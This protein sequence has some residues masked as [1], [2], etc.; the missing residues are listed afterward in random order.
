MPN[1]YY[2]RDLWVEPDV[3]TSHTSNKFPVSLQHLV[4]EL[5]DDLEVHGCNF[6]VLKSRAE[7]IAFK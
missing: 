4:I 7:A 2:P 3:D 5:R 1:D 6:L